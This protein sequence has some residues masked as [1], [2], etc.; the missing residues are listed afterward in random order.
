MQ[1]YSNYQI[2]YKVTNTLKEK[3][4]INLQSGTLRILKV[5][6]F[7]NSIYALIK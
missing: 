4:R 7:D 6:P 2:S 1:M 3:H 5:S